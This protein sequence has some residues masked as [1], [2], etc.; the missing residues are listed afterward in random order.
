MSRVCPNTRAGAAD[1]IEG[2]ESG[3][4]LEDV[5]RLHALFFERPAHGGRFVVLLPAV[6][7]GDDDLADL[8]GVIECGS[9]FDAVLEVGVRPVT[10][11]RC[12]AE[13][14]ADFA[15]LDCVDAVADPLPQ[16]STTACA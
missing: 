15:R 7:A 3:E 11:V 10:A 6:V 13:Q 9:R 12:G 14:E 1:R 16:R 5:L 2:A 4:I 8:S